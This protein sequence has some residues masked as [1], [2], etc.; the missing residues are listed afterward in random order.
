MSRWCEHM[1]PGKVWYF[2]SPNRPWFDQWK[3]CPTCGTPRPKEESLRERLA[4]E[5][6]NSYPAYHAHKD[7]FLHLADT[8]IRIIGEEKRAT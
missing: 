7:V 6:Y 2:D 3:Y 1:K 8:A 5:L 4:R